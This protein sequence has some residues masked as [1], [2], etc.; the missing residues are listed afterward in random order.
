M[1]IEKGPPLDGKPWD[2]FY[3][4]LVNEIR[5]LKDQDFMDIMRKIYDKLQGEKRKQK[6]NDMYD[7][8]GED[9]FDNSMQL[10]NYDYNVSAIAKLPKCSSYLSDGNY[11]KYHSKAQKAYIWLCEKCVENNSDDKYCMEFK[12]SNGNCETKQNLPQLECK[13]VQAPETLT[14]EEEDDSDE[15]PSKERYDNFDRGAGSTT[16]GGIWNKETEIRAHLENELNKYDRIKKHA[17]NITKAWCYVTNGANEEGDYAGEVRRKEVSGPVY[18]LF[19]FWL[20]DKVWNNLG[21]DNT[22]SEVTD[23]IYRALKE[24]LLSEYRCGTIYTDITQE[25]FK[26][27]KI[28]SNYQMDESTITEEPKGEGELCSARYEDY[29]QKVQYAYEIIQKECV[30]HKKSQVV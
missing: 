22:F 16:G 21:R 10:F 12:K 8:I 14:M 24:K 13:G 26:Q 9:V 4:W 25:Y 15:L 3:Y 27:M 19:Y 17:G 11:I 23:K 5:T 30:A 1:E 7:N 6:F 28:L 29:L 18:D 2:F 20:G